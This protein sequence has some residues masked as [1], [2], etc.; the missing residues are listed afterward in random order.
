MRLRTGFKD[1]PVFWKLLVPFAALILIVGAFGAFL[2]VRDLSSRARDAQTQDLQQRSLSVRAFMSDRE[3]YLLESADL[4]A[5]VQGMADAVA[6]ED[7]SAVEEL[8]GSVVALK[9]DL[10]LV[11]GVGDDGD[12]LASLVRSQDRARPRARDLDVSRS[13]IQRVIDSSDDAVV[14]GIERIRGTRML[15]IAAP[16]CADLSPCRAVGAVLVG[17]RLDELARR[18][19]G[20]IEASDPFGVGFVAQDGRVLAGGPP[21]RVDLP[22]DP[23]VSL[24]RAVMVDGTEAATLYTPLEMRGE[25]IGSIAVTLPTEPYLGSVRSAG[26]WL[27]LVLLAALAGIVAIGALV[28]RRITRQMKMLVDANRALG[29]GDLSVRVPVVGRDEIG[30]VAHGLNQMAERLQASYDTLES[31]VEERTQHIDRLL[32]ERT[33]FFASISHEL[34]TPLAVIMTESD[35][36]LDPPY[37][38]DEGVRSGRAIKE[39]TAQLLA[40]VNDILELAKA[41]VGRLEIHA[42]PVDVAEVIDGLRPTIDGLARGA[43]IDAT[44]EVAEDLPAVQAD[45]LRIR[46]VIMNIVDNAVKYTPDGGRL[47]IRVERRPDGVKIL[48]ADSGPGIAPEVGARVF[49]PFFHVEGLEPRRGRSS[50]GLGLALTKQIVDAHGGEIGYESAPGSGSTFWVILPAADA[51]ARRA[52]PSRRLPT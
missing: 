52:R 25:R 18:A 17:I 20:T 30:E 14:G 50:S 23:G 8:F 11:A 19:T 7:G 51:P 45:P 31:R 34:R 6:R 15:T 3:L 16:V 29:T 27:V 33:E 47:L 2:I 43:T 41:E 38:H 10:S 49:D 24:Q 37:D 46:Q 26:V 21:G 28:S 48:V 12:L 42:E 39:S 13:I 9:S 35:L 5:N 44:I 40:V 32:N 36:L 4:A 1:L 22:D